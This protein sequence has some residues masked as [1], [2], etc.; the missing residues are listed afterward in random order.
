MNSGAPR[1]LQIG[2]T[3]ATRANGCPS[4]IGS[5]RVIRVVV[6]LFAAVFLPCFAID[7]R[8]HCFFVIRVVAI[9]FFLNRYLLAF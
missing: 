2:E 4:E 7:V 6:I 9:L 8:Y 1:F 5:E 3:S